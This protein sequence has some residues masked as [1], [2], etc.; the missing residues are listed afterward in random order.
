[1]TGDSVI[2]YSVLTISF[3]ACAFGI[4]IFHASYYNNASN[5]FAYKYFFE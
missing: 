1:M 3:G 2:G 4:F 5:N